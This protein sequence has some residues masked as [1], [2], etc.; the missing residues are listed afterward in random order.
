MVIAEPSAIALSFLVAGSASS[1][2][3]FEPFAMPGPYVL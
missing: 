3:P 2:A 1:L